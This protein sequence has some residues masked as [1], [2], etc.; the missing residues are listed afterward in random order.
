[1]EQEENISFMDESISFLQRHM[2]FSQKSSN[3]LHFVGNDIGLYEVP[4]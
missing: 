3:Y 4:K 1:M 2:S